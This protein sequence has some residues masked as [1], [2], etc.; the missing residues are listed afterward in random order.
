MNKVLFALLLIVSFCSHAQSEN[1]GS[2]LA[3]VPDLT[4][5][6]TGNWKGGEFFTLYIKQPL[7][8]SDTSKWFF[9][10]KVYLTHHDVKKPT[11]LAIDGYS[12]T[13][14]YRSEMTEILD[15]NQI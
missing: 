6:K 1:I 4:Y 10:Q 13:K 11:V 8:H 2:F 9:N 3:D 5:E 15:A 12:V 7:D 14:N